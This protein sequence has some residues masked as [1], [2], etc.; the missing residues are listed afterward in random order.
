M[1]GIAKTNPAMALQ[2]NKMHNTIA[3]RPAKHGQHNSKN[4]LIR[5]AYDALRKTAKIV[6][7]KIYSFFEGI[8][9]YYL[10]E[11]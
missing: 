2:E 11:L 5:F 9:F 8:M 1:H 6:N 3:K 10:M 7:S 4:Q